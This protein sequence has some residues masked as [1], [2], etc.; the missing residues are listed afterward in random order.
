VGPGYDHIFPSYP[1]LR[2]PS[3]SDLLNLKAIP[4]RSSRRRLLTVV[5]YYGKG[6]KT[7]MICDGEGFWN[8]IPK[9]RHGYNKGARTIL[10]SCGAR[11]TG[12]SEGIAWS[13]ASNQQP[14]AALALLLL[15]ARLYLL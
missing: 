13:S 10:G 2:D 12:A 8:H 9:V 3:G 11:G 7:A 1:A 4:G 14:R 5:D 15:L 6:G